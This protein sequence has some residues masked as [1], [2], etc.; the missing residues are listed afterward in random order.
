MA[1][2]TE[3]HRQWALLY[4]ERHEQVKPRPFRVENLSRILAS[5]EEALRTEAVLSPGLV[6]EKK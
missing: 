4:F 3:M 6:P 5:F 2:P 1:K